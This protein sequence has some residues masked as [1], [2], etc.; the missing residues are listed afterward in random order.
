MAGERRGERKE[1]ERERG[2]MFIIIINLF[3]L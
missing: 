1:T 3:F 2:V